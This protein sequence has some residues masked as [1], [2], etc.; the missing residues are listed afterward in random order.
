[1]N[2]KKENFDTLA[3]AMRALIRAA[4]GSGQA[5]AIAADFA[6]RVATLWFDGNN[7]Q[8]LSNMPW[9]I[10]EVRKLRWQ[11]KPSAP[12]QLRIHLADEPEPE[13]SEG[14]ASAAPQQ[15]EGAANFSEGAANLS[16]GAASAAPQQHAP[17]QA[18]ICKAVAEANPIMAASHAHALQEFIEHIHTYIKEATVTPKEY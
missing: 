12:E 2:Q 16:E 10:Q 8:I 13:P 14:A 11:P 4:G 15:S 1:M 7:A 18:Y 5:V 3:S 9:Y 17:V 6:E